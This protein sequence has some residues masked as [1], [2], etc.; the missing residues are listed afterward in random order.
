MEQPV[1]TMR[2]ADSRTLARHPSDRWIG[3]IAA[4]MAHRWGVDPAL[5]RVVFLL[6]A[7]VSGT[8]LIAYGLGWLFL[9]ESRT[10][11]SAARDLTRG[12]PGVAVPLGLALV[13]VGLTRPLLWIEPWPWGYSY[14]G[15]SYG[16]AG[17]VTGW[18][19]LLLALGTV[20]VVVLAR[21]ASRLRVS[22]DGGGSPSVDAA[23]FAGV[24]PFGAVP[25]G[26]APGDRPAWYASGPD[27]G[28]APG[29]FGIGAVPGGPTAGEATGTAT[30]TIPYPTVG[31]GPDP[32]LAALAA[33]RR[34]IPP[35]P[36]R[37]RAPGPGR[38]LS[39]AIGAFALLGPAI[40]LAVHSQWITAGALLIACGAALAALALGV[41]I[42]GIR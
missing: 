23:P 42:S 29:A 6:A 26:A 21:R 40:V 27:D 24:A 11:T 15:G 16:V 25:F 7:M 18:L 10:G 35:R 12:R 20:A 3:G 8:G 28:G 4:G 22:G 30:G 33:A 39:S 14:V 34:L 2:G 31:A 36:R 1:E 19:V 5:V 9:P 37:V 32:E 41:A 13:L 38:R 17:L